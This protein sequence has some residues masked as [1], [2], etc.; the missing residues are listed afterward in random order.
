MEQETTL[1]YDGDYSST[2]SQLDNGSNSHISDNSFNQ[3]NQALAKLTQE[4]HELRQS[5]SANARLS[6]YETNKLRKQ[7]RWLT[8]SLIAAILALGGA[9]TG[10]TL[11]LHNEQANLQ[12]QQRQLSEQ[13]RTLEQSRVNPDQ[14]RRLEQQLN[15][16]NQRTQ[17][18]SEQ[19]RTL[20]EQ[21]PEISSAQLERIQQQLQTLEQRIR[22]NIRDNLSRDAT[23]SQFYSINAMLERLLA[24]QSSQRQTESSNFSQPNQAAQN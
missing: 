13:V 3:T 16:L 4:L 9:L 2:S 15:S 22:D 23:L 1:L 18:L 12:N 24:N 20:I 17:E 5:I 10:I 14:V 7:M 8:G 11:I 19:A 21:V 6:T